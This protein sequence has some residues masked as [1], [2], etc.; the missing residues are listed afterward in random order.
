MKQVKAFQ[1]E[2]GLLFEEKEQAQKHQMFLEK[3][4][5]VQEFIKSEANPYRG[6]SQVAIVGQT[7]INWETWKAKQNAE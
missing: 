7:V 2:D 6:K 3:K 4:G 1:T 5:M